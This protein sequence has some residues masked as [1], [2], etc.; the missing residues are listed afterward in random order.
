MDGGITNCTKYLYNKAGY[1]IFWHGFM[2]TL[3]RA[4]YANSLL[5]YTFEKTKAFNESVFLSYLAH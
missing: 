2:I 5:Y 3:V 4:F 1:G